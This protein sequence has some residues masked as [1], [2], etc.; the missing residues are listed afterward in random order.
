MPAQAGIHVFLAKSSLPLSNRFCPREI[1]QPPKV[2]LT[3]GG[4]PALFFQK[5]NGFSC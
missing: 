4:R 2:F 5:E 3:R 1:P